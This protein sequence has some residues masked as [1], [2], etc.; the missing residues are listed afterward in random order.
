MKRRRPLLGITSFVFRHRTAGIATVTELLD[1]AAR[2]G[3]EVFQLCENTKILEQS[4]K[5]L[6]Q[7]RQQA[8]AS[9]IRLEL[10][11]SGISGNAL[12]IAARV[13]EDLEACLIRAVIDGGNIVPEDAIPLIEKILPRLEQS[14]L[15]LCIENHFR[16][17]PEEI[18]HIVQ[19]L[20]HERVRVCLDPL[21]S[22]ARF[23]GPEESIRILSPLAKT[24]HLKDARIQRKGT[25]WH[26]TGTPLGEG[27]VDLN[28]YL[29]SLPENLVSLLLESW[30]DPLDTPE[31][32][33]QAEWDWAVRGMEW[34]RRNINE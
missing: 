6:G 27:Q 2:L 26:I 22:I 1:L 18:A 34:M 8:A 7:I 10:G 15:Y 14:D 16:F 29:R 23:V 19:R 31:A 12:E 32:T 20:S 3:S 25:G 28:G 4:S 9:G 5:E 30:M 21:N 33:V 13:A 11:I 17:T 24:A